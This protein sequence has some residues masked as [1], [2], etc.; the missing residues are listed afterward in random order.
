M[1][2]V[3]TNQKLYMKEP[4]IINFFLR[5]FTFKIYSLSDN[6]IYTYNF[7]TLII[8]DFDVIAL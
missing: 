8:F 6:M 2:K 7:C 3:K 4:K 5:K 1:R